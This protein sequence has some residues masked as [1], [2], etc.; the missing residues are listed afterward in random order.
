[1]L[2]QV[3][4][5]META[6]AEAEG[7]IAPDETDWKRHDRIQERDVIRPLAS[8]A[9]DWERRRLLPRFIEK[10]ESSVGVAHHAQ[11]NVEDALQNVE[12]SLAK[13]GHEVEAALPGQEAR[14]RYELHVI[15]LRRLE[16]DLLLVEDG[17]RDEYRPLAAGAV[18]QV[19][20]PHLLA[21]SK[22]DRRR[23]DRFPADATHGADVHRE[24]G[25]PKA[26]AG[27]D[28]PPDAPLAALLVLL[29]LAIGNQGRELRD[30]GGW[31]GFERDREAGTRVPHRPLHLAECKG[32]NKR[33]DCVGGRRPVRDSRFVSVI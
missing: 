1:M 20:L 14:S 15:R 8:D 29:Q 3:P 22:S 12:L 31:G 30:V 13:R 19:A 4:V 6:L 10:R 17:R 32:S 2:A 33:G 16:E 18:L 25:G 26:L 23:G 7:P 11:T 27:L 21:V 5:E 28:H 24:L 9:E